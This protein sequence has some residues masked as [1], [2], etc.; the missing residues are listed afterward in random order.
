M[1][2]H[3]GREPRLLR[4]ALGLGLSVLGIGACSNEDGL[5]VT[6]E[7]QVSCAGEEPSEE[8]KKA[9]PTM[10]P[11]RVCGACHRA[12]GQA[13]NS[14]WQVS[15]TVYRSKT[16]ACN[17]TE[18][19]PPM[20]VEIL[21]GQHDPKGAYRY[22]EVQPNGRMRPNSVGNFYSSNKFVAPLVARVCESSGAD[23][24]GATNVQTM[25]MK[26]GLDPNSN[27][28]VRV[29]CN[30]CHYSGGQAGGRIYLN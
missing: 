16:S 6:P 21:Y 8:M 4:L 20:I 14:P 10:L 7:A 26:V 24:S 29:D 30:L 5:T 27:T 19:R 25:T 17:A 11:G 15:G 23:C 3:R 22:G 9:G 13:L 18:T 28:F 12:G 1:S 2:S